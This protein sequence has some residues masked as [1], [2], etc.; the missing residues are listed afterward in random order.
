[1]HSTFVAAAERALRLWMPKERAD[2]IIGDLAEVAPHKG[3]GWFWFSLSKIIL[4]LAWRPALGMMAGLYAGSW[5]TGR[6]GAMIWGTD[7]VHRPPPSWINVFGVIDGATVV[8]IFVLPYAVLRYGVQDRITA[9]AACWA[10]VLTLFLCEWDRPAVLALCIV[11]AIGVG[12]FS[13][14]KSGFR[15]SSI[16]LL[17][18]VATGIGCGLAIMAL[19]ALLRYVVHPGPWGSADSAHCS[20]IWFINLLFVSAV[21]MTDALFTRLRTWSSRNVSE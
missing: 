7:P 8:L 18:I 10:G 5:A 2:S 12:V 9:L 4:F 13:L 20:T 11:L 19:D 17:A 16:G 21:C 3:N 1:M 14:Y 6:F 15:R